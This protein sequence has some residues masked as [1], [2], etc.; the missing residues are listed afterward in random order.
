MPMRAVIEQ[1]IILQM[2]STLLLKN[3]G[4][5]TAEITLQVSY[6]IK[7]NETDKISIQEFQLTAIPGQEKVQEIEFG[8][9]ANGDLEVL[10][11]V[12]KPKGNIIV[13]KS[14]ILEEIIGKRHKIEF[15]AQDDIELGDPDIIHNPPFVYGRLLDKKGVKDLEDVQ[16]II[17]VKKENE[18]DFLPLTSV[19]TEVKGYFTFEYPAGFFT[20]AVASIGL[21]LSENPMPIKLDTK[22]VKISNERGVE[23]EKDV[24]V[25][26]RRAI[27]VVDVNEN[28]ADKINTTD[29]GCH[30]DEFGKKKVLEEFSFFSLIRTS[31]PEIK[32]YVLEDEDEITLWEVLNNL[33]SSVLDLFDTIKAVPFISKVSPIKSNIIISSSRTRTSRGVSAVVPRNEDDK[34]NDTLKA[35]KINKGV[36]SN[37]I[38]EEKTITKENISKLFALNDADKLHKAVTNKPETIKPLGRVE[39]GLANTVDWDDEPT[40]YQAVSIAH[41]HLLQFKSEWLADGYSLGDLLYSLPLAPGQKKQIVVFDWERRES[42]ANEQSIDF[43]ESLNNSLTRDRDISEIAAGVLQENMKGGSTSKVRSVSGGISF[44]VGGALIG[45]SGGGSNARTNAW[46]NNLRQTSSSD[47]QKLRDR[48]V[49][50]A[51]A[52]RNMRSTVIQTVSQGERFEISSESVANYN[53]CHAM[54]I[55]YYEVLRH[56]KIRQRFAE[57]K[58]VLFVP[59]LMTQFTKDK[60]LRWRESLSEVLIDRRLLKGFDAADRVEHQWKDSGF[61]SGTFASQNIVTASGTLKIQF[62]IQRPSDKSDENGKL[63]LD[64]GAWG[65]FNFLFGSSFVE[66]FYKD[67]LENQERKDEIFH[68]ELGEKIARRFIANLSFQILDETQNSLGEVPI[69]ASLTSRYYK[70][71]V[72]NVKLNWNTALR[73]RDKVHYLKISMRRNLIDIVNPRPLLPEGSFITVVSG[74]MNY[75]TQFSNGTLFKFQNIGDDLSSYDGVTIYTGPSTEELKD[76]RKED[77]NIVNKLIAHLND[78]LE[79][80]H[81]AIWL[82][83]TPERRFMLLDGIVL[84]GKGEGRSVASLVENELLT[85][86]GNSLVFPVASGLNLNPDFGQ[87]E[88][89]TEYYMTAAA[90]PI[91]I[92]VPTKGVFAE[93]VMGK[94]NSCEKIDESRFW[95]WEESPIPDSP[96]A[97]NPINT[98]SRRADPGNLQP[99]QMPNPIVNIQNAP[100]APDPTG[101]AGT[102]GLLGQSNLFKDITGIEGT[103]RNAIQGL[104]STLD[105]AKVFAQESAKLETQKMMERRL[106]K[107]MNAIDADDSLSPEK[108]A[109]LKEKA[110]NAYMGAGATKEEK[111]EKEQPKPT[112]TDAAVK[113]SEQGKTVKAT[114]SDAEGVIESVEISGSSNST[115]LAS[116]SGAIPKLKQPNEN[117]CWA[118]AATIMMSWKKGKLFTEEEVLTEVG[119]PY[120]Q[121][122]LNKEP[123][124][125]SHK[126]DFID[127]LYMSGE[128]P[129]SYPLQQYIDWVNNFGPVWI[130]TDS[131][132]QDGAFSPHARILTK[133]IG[134]GTPDGVGTH[135]IFIDPS[136]GTEQKESFENFLKQ[137]EQ[138]VTDNIG[139]LFIQIVHFETEIYSEGRNP[140]T[141]IDA[142]VTELMNFDPIFADTI[143]I[144]KMEFNTGISGFRNYKNWKTDSSVLHNMTPHRRK[145]YRQPLDIQFI[146]L[147]E[148]G[149]YSGNAF[150]LPANT[151]SHMTVKAD[152]TILQFNDLIETEFHTIN[153]NDVAIGIEFVNRSW[154]SHQTKRKSNGILDLQLNYEGITTEANLT[155]EQKTEYA[156]SNG[157]LWLF[158]GDGFN[159]YRVPPNLTQLEKLVDL[160]KWLLVDYNNYV[161]KIA[162]TGTG[163][164]DFFTSISNVWLQIVSFNEVSGIWTF[165]DSDIPSEVDKSKKMFFIF[166][167]GYGL[168]DP[169]I[170][171]TNLASGVLSHNACMDNHTDGSF[172]TLYS[173]L[174]IQKLKT[175]QDA[176]EISKKLMKNNHIKVS[177]TSNTSKKIHL[178]NVDDGNLVL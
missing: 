29:C 174:R 145:T 104:Q 138:M 48:I 34:I 5:A 88:S 68:N 81:R 40:I 42:A 86:V 33:P 39:L 97:I 107:A 56:F 111:K 43:E 59:L 120:L 132:E 49:Q 11:L 171:K 129:A 80:Y 8:E 90:E 102:L 10:I 71:G 123:L 136:T 65:F 105:T 85:V 17:L 155:Q 31:Q 20:E 36:L 135:F 87:K 166:S 152:D 148:S 94:C 15:A 67:Y 73:Q 134:T 44:P 62:V 170:L 30:A 146:V 137:Y 133:I 38:R 98:D 117:A 60:L 28:V 76:P 14:F 96:T 23:E 141:K 149:T 19:K 93:A 153:M 50:S 103:Q 89:L 116:F 12:E 69:D 178:L 6:H 41:G 140:G 122:F 127:L 54:T 101:L 162:S 139:K 156:E 159:I 92:S 176:Y 74:L 125:S 168:L 57:A 100:N 144:N 128:P 45:V 158:W 160:V 51:N 163:I 78:N 79:Y 9:S 66:N 4:D 83:M 131:S 52:V 113:A 143:V 55:Q 61:P 24:L 13:Q 151:T 21:D 109:E 110:L 172:P 35:V 119:N 7:F 99:Q 53:H 126:S 114:K 124:R 1:K 169:A 37:F 157:H 164:Y 130:T 32:G 25:F 150:N 165:K 115:I 22:K 47:Q 46:Q 142:R 82:N 2:K 63:I 118:T 58:E 84:N 64:R 18:N 70:D 91:S 77:V 75:R 26:P 27:L 177:L 95:R 167:T 147:H 154:L 175:A 173:W 72:L 3:I 106:D 16:I 112:L 108:K 161:N 121:N